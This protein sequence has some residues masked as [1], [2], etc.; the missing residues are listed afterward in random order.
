MGTHPPFA[1]AEPNDLSSPRIELC[2]HG[3]NAV[4]SESKGR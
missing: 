3:C 1:S 2:P 4:A